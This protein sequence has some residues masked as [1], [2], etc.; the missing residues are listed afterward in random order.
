MQ[1]VVFTGERGLE[2]MNF[3]DPT[4]ERVRSCWR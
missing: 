4:P 1:G 3:A 2:I